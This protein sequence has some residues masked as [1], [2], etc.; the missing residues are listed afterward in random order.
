M[1]VRPV[2]PA[3]LSEPHRTRLLYVVLL[4][5]LGLVPNNN[6]DSGVLA[7]DSGYSGIRRGMDRRRGAGDKTPPAGRRPRP[8]ENSGNSLC[9]RTALWELVRAALVRLLCR[10]CSWPSF[11]GPLVVGRKR[12]GSVRRA[13]DEVLVLVGLGRRRLHGVRA[14]LQGR[15]CKVRLPGCFGGIGQASRGSGLDP[16]R[17]ARRVRSISVWPW[18]AARRACTGT[19]TM[20][21]R[22][23]GA[24]DTRRGSASSCAAAEEETGAPR[25]GTPSRRR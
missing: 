5:I 24:S 4:D 8:S 11:L 3:P 9:G 6:N 7:R 10:R 13:Q 18:E 17:A 12:S 23:L 16:L 2:R 14:V 15:S 19:S 21:R 20:R 1:P 22:T 25:R